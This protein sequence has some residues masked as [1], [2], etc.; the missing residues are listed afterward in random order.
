MILKNTDKKIVRVVMTTFQD[1]ESIIQSFNGSFQIK[2]GKKY[3]MYTETDEKCSLTS[4]GTLV[5]LNRYDSGRSLI[6]EQGEQHI[7]TYMTSAGPITL[8][9]DTFKITDNLENGTLSIDYALFFEG[10]EPIKNK[11]NI[12]IEEI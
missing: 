4:D 1:G 3:L 2:N 11:I 9:T 12:K 5:R 8:T 6:F 7:S 10:Q